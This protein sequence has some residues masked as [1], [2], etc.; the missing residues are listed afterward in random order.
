[1]AAPKQ[2]QLWIV[3]VISFVLF[4]LLAITGLINWL[5]L[6]H[7]GGRRDGSVIE[8]RHLIRDAHTWLAVFFL[9]A[10]IIHLMLHWPYIRSNLVKIGWLSKK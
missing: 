5:V 6:P 4:F 2:S 1:M 3:N 7:G 10:V 8:T 9:I